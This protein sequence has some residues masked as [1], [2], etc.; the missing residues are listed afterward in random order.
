[1]GV[2][3][4]GIGG[5]LPSI[6]SLHIAVLAGL[7]PLSCS[8]SPSCSPPGLSGLLVD[9]LGFHLTLLLDCPV[10]FRGLCHLRLFSPPFLSFPSPLLHHF[11]YASVSLHHFGVC[12]T[13]VSFRDFAQQQTAKSPPWVQLTCHPFLLLSLPDLLC[14]VP[15]PRVSVPWRVEGTGHLSVWSSRVMVWSHQRQRKW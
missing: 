11:P 1:M 8:L 6:D 13:H 14:C 12:R 3:G 10:P 15:F 7:F 2:L 9:W 5:H 4:P